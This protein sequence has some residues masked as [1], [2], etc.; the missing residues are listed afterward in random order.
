M[1]KELLVS[2]TSGTNVYATLRIP[3]NRNHATGGTNRTSG[4]IGKWFN[5]ATLEFVLFAA[6]DFADYDIALAELG[7]T[8]L[9]EGDMPVE[10]NPEKALEVIYW[11]RAGAAPVVGDTKITGVNF[12]F[13]DEW[14]A[15]SSI[16]V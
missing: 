16:R 4:N 7:D 12:E 2:H 8:G 15:M 13:L 1:S 5:Q 6:G 9:F 14:V 11:E 10:A 3:I